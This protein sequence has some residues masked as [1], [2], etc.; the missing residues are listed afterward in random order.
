[1]QWV[2]IDCLLTEEQS[3]AS[4]KAALRC[5]P[6]RRDRRSI[7]PD[8]RSDHG[9]PPPC[10]HPRS[11]GG[12]RRR[13][14]CG[15]RRRVARER[16][17]RCR[18]LLRHLRL[19]H[20]RRPVA[21]PAATGPHL[22]ACVL[23]P[24][25]T[26]DPAARARRP[27]PHRLGVR[28]GAHRPAG[29]RGPDRRPL[30]SILPVELAR[31]RGRERLLR[32]G[33]RPVASPALLVAGGGG[34]VLPGVAVAGRRRARCRRASLVGAGAPSGCSALRWSSRHWGGRRCRAVPTRPPRSTR[35]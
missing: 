29:R 5:D 8:A 26:P 32:A 7:R 15:A 35:R 31:R 11:A 20:H 22:A 16:V 28:V 21:R 10:G 24:A 19:R 14:G 9:R 23:R 27:G 30:G 6:V 13:R 17:P 4:P 25:R 18:R 2:R 1:M 12:G 34:A 3:A 33:R